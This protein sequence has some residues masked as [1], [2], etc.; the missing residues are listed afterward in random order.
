MPTCSFCKK[1]Y[2]IPRGLTI[3]T[4][5]GRTVHYCSSKCRR[6]AAL[7]RDPKKTNWVKREKSDG[8]KIK[9]QEERKEEMKKDEGKEKEGEIEK[10]IGKVK[11]TED[12]KEDKE[13]K[14]VEDKVEKKEESEESDDEDDE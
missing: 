6:N 14:K 12:L 4:F 3:F 8:K 10:K 5:E 2:E 13:M 9:K 7:K 11:K 1:N